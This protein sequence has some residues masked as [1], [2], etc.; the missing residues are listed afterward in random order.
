MYPTSSE[1]LNKETADAVYFFTPA[2]APLD[3]C[4]AHALDLWGITFQTAEHAYQWKKYIDTYPDIA[5]KI[6]AAKSPETAKEISDSHKAEQPANWSKVKISIMEEILTAKA[7]QHA[8]VREILRRTGGRQIV[9]NSPVDN[10]WG[11]GPNKNGTNMLGKIWMK[12][13]DAV[14]EHL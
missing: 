6:L 5:A 14:I 13:R 10:F 4:S 1:G 9:E 3:N 8:D 11:T 7:Q 2:F 12:I